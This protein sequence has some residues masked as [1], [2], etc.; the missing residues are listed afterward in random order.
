MISMATPKFMKR[1]LGHA[2]WT[3]A[4]L[5][6][7]H[8]TPGLVSAQIKFRKARAKFRKFPLSAR[9]RQMHRFYTRPGKTTKTATSNRPRKTCECLNCNVLPLAALMRRCVGYGKLAGIAA[10]SRRA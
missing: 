2:G 6:R 10:I 8:V 7:Q 4:A 5:A 3:A 1:E 9:P